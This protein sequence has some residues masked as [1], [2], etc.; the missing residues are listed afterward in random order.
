MLTAEHVGL[1]FE[2]RG[3]TVFVGEE[4]FPFIGDV[5]RLESRQGLLLVDTDRGH[6]IICGTEP[7]MMYAQFLSEAA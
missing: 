1:T 4:F 6:Y 5:I 3:N 7:R 2:A